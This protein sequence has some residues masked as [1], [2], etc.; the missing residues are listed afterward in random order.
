M[1]GIA[2]VVIALFGIGFL[3]SNFLPSK[4]KDCT[5]SSSRFCYDKQTG[6]KI[7]GLESKGGENAF[8]ACFKN[9]APNEYGELVQKTSLCE[10]ERFQYCYEGKSKVFLRKFDGECKPSETPGTPS[11]ASC[12]SVPAL[13]I[14]SF[15]EPGSWLGR[16]NN[17]DIETL[18]QSKSGAVFA[19]GTKYIPERVVFIPVIYKSL[20]NGKNWVS[21]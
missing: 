7:I 16:Y 21:T 14:Y 10:E 13:Q 2:A 1:L 8:A 15:V 18:F 11:T 17:D 3:A 4:L 6:K 9:A 20:D 5:L 19:G 12:P